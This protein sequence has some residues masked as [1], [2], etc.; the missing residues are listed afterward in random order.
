MLYSPENKKSGVTEYRKQ[1]IARTNNITLL[2]SLHFRLRGN[3]ESRLVQVLLSLSFIFS[4]FSYAR[5]MRC[6]NGWRTTSL[7]V[8]K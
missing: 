2:F 5:T 6:T 3:D 1:L 7:A 8:K 4:N